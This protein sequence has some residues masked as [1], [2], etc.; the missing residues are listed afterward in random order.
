MKKLIV[1]LFPLY[2]FAAIEKGN[3]APLEPIS[4]TPFDSQLFPLLNPLT[5]DLPFDITISGYVKNDTFFDTRQVDALAAGHFLFFPKRKLPDVCGDDINAHGNYNILAIQSRLRATIQGPTFENVKGYAVIEGDF[6]GSF[7]EDFFLGSTLINRF[8]LRHAF[9]E[10]DWP[11][12]SILAGQ[13]WHPMEYPVEAP[14]TVSFNTGAPI[15]VFN[16]SPQL[17]VTFVTDRFAVLFAALSEV[18]F[19]SDGPNLFSSKYIQNGIVPNLDAQIQVKVGDHTLGVGGDFKR[20]VP[21]LVTNKDF[22]ADESIISFA[23]MG[24][25]ELLFDPISVY[26]HVLYAEN[27]TDLFLLGGYAVHCV[28]Q[29]TDKRTYT[30]RR[31]VS[32]WTDAQIDC[33]LSP[34]IFIGYT[35]NLGANRTIVQQAQENNPEFIF[36]LDPEIDY[37]FRVSP[38]LVYS[39]KAFTAAGEIEFTRAAFGQL[40]NKAE[41]INAVPVNNV[42][43]LFALYYY[44]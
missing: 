15:A 32:V 12:V 35:K 30:N 24:Y 16:R 28:D 7:S 17:R 21:R 43:F 39:N 18:Q 27:G 20:L 13:T 42:R 23:T 44:V 37:V 25:A 9:F 33:A 5:R 2:I 4:K 40:N 11:N 19:R 29:E 22:K 26:F 31:V 34:G 8:E 41:V 36:G 10:L 14:R 6:F 1:L 3:F 38:R